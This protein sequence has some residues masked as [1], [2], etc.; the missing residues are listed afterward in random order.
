MPK[1]P[2]RSED[3]LLN[4]LTYRDLDVWQRAMQLVKMVYQLTKKLPEDELYALSNQMRKAAI[5]VPSNIAEGY[6]RNSKT[7]YIQFLTIAKGSNSELRTQLMISVDIEYLA[8]EDV[9]EALDA[10][11]EV[12][13]MLSTLIKKL[14][15][16][17]WPLTPE[18]W[19][20]SP[21]S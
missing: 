17:S 14:S 1:A 4:I 21:D 11:E 6:E 13:K 10:C 20:R 5:S 19:P 2:E 9:Q 15:P 8:G 7:E 16:G 12:S 18:P 3:N